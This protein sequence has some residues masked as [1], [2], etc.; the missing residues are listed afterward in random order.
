MQNV[1]A[2]QVR[3]IGALILRETRSAFGTTQL[4]YLWAILMPAASVAVM[5]VI[6]T[7]MGRQP[8]FGSSLALFFAT[9]VLTLEHY[10]KLSDSLMAALGAN[11]ALLTY[12]P[13]KELDVLFARAILISV[14]YAVILILFL[15]GLMAFDLAEFPSYPEHVFIAFLATAFLGFGMGIFNAVVASLW[16]SWKR[17]EKILTR[18]LFFVSGIFYIP[19]QL[20]P[21]AQE[22]LQWNP[23]LHLVEWMR[24]G[25]YPNYESTVLTKTYPIVAALLLTFLGLVGERLYRRKRV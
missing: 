20:P 24:S 7:S 21:K 6:F 16:D 25:Y 15:S 4:G 12:P 22:I 1:L 3:V 11:K 17:I 14:T 23:V 10:R 8:P 2:I 13:I 19:S 5:V 9:G 18:P